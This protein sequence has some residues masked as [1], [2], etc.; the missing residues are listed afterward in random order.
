MAREQRET[1]NE[2]YTVTNAKRK[3]GPK[4]IPEEHSRADS[5]RVNY[6]KIHAAGGSS[7]A[8]GI[9]ESSGG[10]FAQLLIRSL[11]R[12]VGCVPG[13]NARRGWFFFAGIFHRAPTLGTDSDDAVQMVGNLKTVL[14]CNLVLQRLELG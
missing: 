13:L 4:A 1:S 3:N 8:S 10:A 5:L 7:A 12:S 2:S 11:A 6:A 9:R 14:G